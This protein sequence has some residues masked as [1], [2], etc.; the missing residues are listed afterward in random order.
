[1]SAS[2]SIMA[3]VP[4]PAAREEPAPAALKA[5]PAV[6][7]QGA[8]DVVLAR[9]AKGLRGARARTG[10]SEADVV[11]ILVRQGIAL[12][13]LTLRSAEITGVIPLA[14]AACLA[15]VYGTTTDGLA[16]RRLH[17]KR[18]SLDDFPCDS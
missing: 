12:D 13:V 7:L 11:A 5:A 6:A 1:M 2:T 9:V 8:P 14:L 17:R 10:L 16:G 15:D 18:L 3:L 4:P